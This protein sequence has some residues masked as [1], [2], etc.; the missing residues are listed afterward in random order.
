MLLYPRSWVITNPQMLDPSPPIILDVR[1][2][3]ALLYAI[4]RQEIVDTLQHGLVEVAHGYL[5]PNEPDYPAVERFVVRYGYDPRRAAAGL[6]ELGYARSPDGTLL[7]AAGQPLSI[8]TRTVSS[9]AVMLSIADYW[10]RQGISVTPSI[11]PPQRRQDREYRATWPGFEVQ[12]NSNDPAT[13]SWQHSSQVPLPSNNY[14]G[15][16]K[17]RYMNPE[18]DAL[19]DRY[20]ATIPRPERAQVLGQIVHHISD[21]LISMPIFYQAEPMLV[22]HRL[23]NVQP[24]GP[25]STSAWNAHEWNVASSK[26]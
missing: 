18:F 8:E 3:R 11:T 24:Q 12:Q 5:N 20:Y 2:R 6:E 4:D 14:S 19:I 16:S 22:G 25:G 1:F 17:N 13:L 9:E 23:R 15:R 21:Q 10:Q 26:D 7:D